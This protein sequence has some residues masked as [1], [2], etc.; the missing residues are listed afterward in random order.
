MFLF[1]FFFITRSLRVGRV[2]ASRRWSKCAHRD[3]TVGFFCESSLPFYFVLLSLDWYKATSK[4]LIIK[5]YMFFNCNVFFLLGYYLLS[6]IACLPLPCFIFLTCLFLK[7][8]LFRASS[9]IEMYL[10]ILEFS[11]HSRDSY[12]SGLFYFSTLARLAQNQYPEWQ[13]V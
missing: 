3:G 9:I 5:A 4:H 11:S 8:S 10:V 1:L 13:E 2:R 12:D 7:T 6:T